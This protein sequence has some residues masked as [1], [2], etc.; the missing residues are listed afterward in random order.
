MTE[1]LLSFALAAANIL[2][3][4]TAVRSKLNSSLSLLFWIHFSKCLYTYYSF[5]SDN[6]ILFGVS[7]LINLSAFLVFCKVQSKSN[8]K[9]DFI[10][11]SFSKEKKTLKEWNDSNIFKSIITLL[12]QNRY[13]PPLF[14]P[15]SPLPWQGWPKCLN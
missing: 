11:R 6:I 14:D 7:D 9:F 15:F 2:N 3:K 8:R 1:N 4:L 13:W 12:D 5:F 10:R